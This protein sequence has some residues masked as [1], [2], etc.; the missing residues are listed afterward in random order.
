MAIKWTSNPAPYP[1]LRRVYVHYQ[2]FEVGDL[3]VD[4][5]RR[6]RFAGFALS[7]HGNTQ[8]FIIPMAALLALFSALPI[9]RLYRSRFA[10][11]KAGHCQ[12]CGYDLRASG[13]VARSVAHRLSLR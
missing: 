4:I 9:G 13:E 7:N 10:R 6:W 2:S 11:P 5:H 12:K 8:Y 3:Y 1:D